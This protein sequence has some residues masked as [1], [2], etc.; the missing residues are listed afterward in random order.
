MAQWGGES[1]GYWTVKS[2]WR[3]HLSQ[4]CFQVKGQNDVIMLV[5]GRNCNE[6]VPQ[7]EAVR[8]CGL[9]VLLLLPKGLVIQLLSGLMGQP[10]R[11]ALR[12]A[13]EA[14]PNGSAHIRPPGFVHDL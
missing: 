13:S 2:K 11:S 5:S 12:S 8:R 14:L 4:L 3:F 7:R 9:S 10:R 6:I 1:T